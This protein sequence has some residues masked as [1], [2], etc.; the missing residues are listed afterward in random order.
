[1]LQINLLNKCVTSKNSS[2]VSSLLSAEKTRENTFEPAFMFCDEIESI[3]RM[4]STVNFEQEILITSTGMKSLMLCD[5]VPS[6]TK[7]P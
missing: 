4:A 6:Q 7:L 3:K 5:N 2:V 1:M